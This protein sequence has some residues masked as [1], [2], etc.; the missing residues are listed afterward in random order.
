MPNSQ[1]LSPTCWSALQCMLAGRVAMPVSPSTPADRLTT[2]NQ[3]PFAGIDH[4]GYGGPGCA[5]CPLTPMA[6]SHCSSVSSQSLPQPRRWP[7]RCRAGRTARHHRPPAAWRRRRE[8]PP[9]GRHLAAFGFHRA[10]GLAEIFGRGRRV[11]HAAGYWRADVSDVG[12]SAPAAPRA[13]VA[14][15]GGL[16]PTNA[17]RPCSDLPRRHIRPSCRLSG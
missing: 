8:Y 3:T 16:D 10:D 4:H 9:R 1:A 11:S 17:T 7:P 15:A 2:H 5:P 6:V 12:P 13:T 14:G